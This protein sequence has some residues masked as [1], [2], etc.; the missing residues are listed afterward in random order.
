MDFR[1][2]PPPPSPVTSRLLPFPPQ[3]H[4]S[5][6]PPLLLIST[7]S[8]FGPSQRQL[9]ASEEVNNRGAQRL[10][11]PL[12][13]GLF[14][15]QWGPQWRQGGTLSG[16]VQCSRAPIGCVCHVQSRVLTAQYPF[17]PLL[18]KGAA[19]L[20]RWT[21]LPFPISSFF[22]IPILH[23]SI[24][25]SIPLLTL[26]FSSVLLEPTSPRPVSR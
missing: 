26:I 13:L 25:P 14:P 22:F 21:R 15:G 17:P 3:I 11:Y 4:H 2:A 19:T 16:M 24:E 6:G 7:G 23:L 10:Y 5:S 9:A 18:L 12:F 8:L 20:L 1:R